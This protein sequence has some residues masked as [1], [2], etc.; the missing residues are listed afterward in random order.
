MENQKKDEQNEQIRELGSDIS[1]TS[2]NTTGDNYGCK[3]K[4]YSFG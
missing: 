1:K 3:N 2:Y 4:C